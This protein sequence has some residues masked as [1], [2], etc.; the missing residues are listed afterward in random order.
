VE[1]IAQSSQWQ[2]WYQ[3]KLAFADMKDGL[4]DFADSVIYFLLMLPV[5]VL[6]ILAL[7]LLITVSVKVL[8]W[9]KRKF[10]PRV[11]FPFRRT[12]QQN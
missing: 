11:S 2:P 3:T 8:V 4:I 5:I 6:W 1:S 9:V 12:R 10:L 7:V